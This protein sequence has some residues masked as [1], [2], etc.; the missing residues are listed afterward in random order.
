MEKE[1]GL[2][3]WQVPKPEKV[4]MRDPRMLDKTERHRRE[5]NW[6]VRFLIF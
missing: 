3:S 6:C 5:K 1:Y 2:M 4:M